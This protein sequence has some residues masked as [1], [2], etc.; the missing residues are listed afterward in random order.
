MLSSTPRLLG[1][2]LLFASGGTTLIHRSVYM[3]AR[4]GPATAAEL[5]ASLATFMLASAGMLL[6]IHGARLFAPVVFLPPG[7]P[8]RPTAS[9]TPMRAALT[10][11]PG[12]ACDTRRGIA[13]LQARRAL[14]VA[15]SLKRDAAASDAVLTA[16]NRRP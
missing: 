16:D 10:D 3:A 13:S 14:A 15:V 9:L 1:L 2:L 8:E 5:A 11:L 7:E 6:L 12:S 4:H